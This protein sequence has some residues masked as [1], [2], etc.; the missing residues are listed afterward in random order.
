MQGKCLFFLQ[1]ANQADV[2]PSLGLVV[3]KV[4]FKADVY[5]GSEN[6]VDLM[7]VDLKKKRS[8]NTKLKIF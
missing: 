2:Q 3:Q 1:R 6:I 4:Y 8:H 5:Y 7:I